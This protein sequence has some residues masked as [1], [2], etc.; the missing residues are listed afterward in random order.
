ME[1]NYNFLFSF[2]KLNNVVLNESLSEVQNLRSKWDSETIYCSFRSS[3]TQN[4]VQLDSPWPAQQSGQ[5][6]VLY[7][8]YIQTI[9]MK[10]S[11]SEN[12]RCAV[13]FKVRG[14]K[15]DLS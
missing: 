8:P 11:A 15:A 9:I 2:S 6:T 10:A 5:A 4:Y 12:D 14:L 13:T 1:L 7:C 3:C